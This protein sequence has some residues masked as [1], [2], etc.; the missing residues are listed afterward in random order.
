[1]KNFYKITYKVLV[2]ELLILQ[3][4]SLE[5]FAGIA[6]SSVVSSQES[7][8]QKNEEAKKT[9]NISGKTNGWVLF[10]SLNKHRFA[11]SP[12]YSLAMNQDDYIYSNPNT[13]EV[14]RIGRGDLW[15]KVDVI[16]EESDQNNQKWAYISF[17]NMLLLENRPLKL[18]LISS[19]NKFLIEEFSSL[20]GLWIVVEMLPETEKNSFPF[21]G[22]TGWGP[23]ACGTLLGYLSSTF[24]VTKYN[25]RI[26]NDEN[27]DKN[28]ISDYHLPVASP[29]Q[30]GSPNNIGDK[31]NNTKTSANNN[32]A[33]LQK[34][35]LSMQLGYGAASNFNAIL[36]F[37]TTYDIDNLTGISMGLNYDADFLFPDNIA[38]F[39]NVLRFSIEG[40]SNGSKYLLPFSVILLADQYDDLN[41]V[42]TYLG[43]GTAS[44]FGN[45]SEGL[46]LKGSIKF[47]L[48]LG[49]R[50]KIGARTI[51]LGLEVG[52]TDFG[53]F[54]RINILCGLFSL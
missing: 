54:Y 37:P 44:Y 35:R 25:E 10:S 28:I 17:D 39:S 46:G 8:V 4:F 1:M 41:R 36:P 30:E 22:L 38:P 14:F 11:L 12:P 32:E 29:A 26:I 34:K 9:N 47:I 16:S 31:Q 2:V 7:F 42:R 24:L 33:N 40:M 13:S 18:K 52:T 48:G 50:D 5:C 51:E 15:D 23:I 20:A 21:V 45:Y 6:S 19:L 3:L 43:I 53:R 27:K 49:E